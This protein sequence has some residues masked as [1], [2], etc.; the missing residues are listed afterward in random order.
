MSYEE[1][2]VEFIKKHDLDV[3]SMVIVTRKVDYS[4]DTWKDGWPKY[5]DD[6]IGNEYEIEGIDKHGI[7]LS[8]RDDRHGDWSFPYSSLK[9]VKDDAILKVKCCE[10]GDDIEIENVMCTSCH[11][12]ENYFADG[13]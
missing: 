7:I 3:G 11:S 9:P 5:M 1:E 12:E 4:I 8:Y 10:C 13:I 6:A 2:Q